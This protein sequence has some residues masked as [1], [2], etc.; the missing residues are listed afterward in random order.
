MNFSEPLPIDSILPRLTAA[1]R[2]GR[3]AVLVAPPGA[4]KTSRGPLV[5]AGEAW[6]ENKK[7]IV[8]E[9]R[10]LAAPAAAARRGATPGGAVGGTAGER[11]PR[12]S[13]RSRAPPT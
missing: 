8:L 11:P 4:G 10:R 7:I 6:A 3:A 9:P 5:L 2:V 13:A 1:L 12:C